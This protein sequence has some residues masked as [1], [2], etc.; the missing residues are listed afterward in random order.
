MDF[1]RFLTFPCGRTAT[2]ST[3]LA[4]STAG[5]LAMI[6][7]GPHALALM[8]IPTILVIVGFL[9]AVGLAVGRFG[10]V[11]ISMVIA[12]PLLA[13]F[14]FFGLNEVIGKG[15]ALG[16]PLVAL[17]ILL[18]VTAGWAYRFVGATAR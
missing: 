6:A 4:I 16:A 1:R 8:T 11:A 7:P 13:G 12:L 17:G 10:S 3:G 5:I 14:Y 9:F 18:M 2:A 15:P